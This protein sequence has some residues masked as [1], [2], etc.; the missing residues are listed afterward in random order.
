[1]YEQI[2][3]PNLWLDVATRK[4]SLLKENKYITKSNAPRSEGVQ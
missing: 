3:Q 2:E 4:L 1:M